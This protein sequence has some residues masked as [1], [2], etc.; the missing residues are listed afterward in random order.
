MTWLDKLKLAVAI[1]YAE[2]R[3]GRS[4]WKGKTGAVGVML[5]ALAALFVD[6]SAGTLSTEKAIAYF[7]AFSA[8]LSA[9]GIRS[10][11][12]PAQP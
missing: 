3:M 5:G 12:T 6:F 10:A 2:D 9:F 4:G 11:L 8:G 1:R 7:T